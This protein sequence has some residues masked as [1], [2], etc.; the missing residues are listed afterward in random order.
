MSLD[1]QPPAVK[2]AAGGRDHG[3][4]LM[5]VVDDN[6]EEYVDLASVSRKEDSFGVP[7][8]WHR[9]T[10][11]AALGFGRQPQTSPPSAPGWSGT[12]GGS[13]LFPLFGT[14]SP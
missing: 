5:V 10:K 6:M 4:E 9:D 11:S 8:T 2:V 1:E 14:P 12:L 13:P 7:W 3:E